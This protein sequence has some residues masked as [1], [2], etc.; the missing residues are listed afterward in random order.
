MAGFEDLNKDDFTAGSP[1]SDSILK[2]IDDFYS[3]KSPDPH[4]NFLDEVITVDKPLA[5]SSE[6]LVFPRK[7][8]KIKPIHP[9]VLAKLNENYS[10]LTE[11][12]LTT[13]LTKEI[14]NLVFSV[15]KKQLKDWVRN[16]KAPVEPKQQ[17]AEPIILKLKYTPPAKAPN[18][19]PQ[20]KPVVQKIAAHLKVQKPKPQAIPIIPKIAGHSKIQKPPQAKSIV[21]KNE[22]NFSPMHITILTAIFREIFNPSEEKLKNFIHT[23]L[24]QFSR[25][26]LLANVASKSAEVVSEKS[27]VKK[28]PQAIKTGRPSIYNNHQIELLTQ[29]YKASSSPSEKELQK[30]QQQMPQFSTKQLLAWRGHHKELWNEIEIPS[31]KS[32]T[33]KIGIK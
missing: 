29:F 12:T 14:K 10:H 7:A 28:T 27:S 21:Q 2:E 15:T 5:E 19:Q 17:S 31:G 25:T 13:Q 9:T 24:P 23:T 1:S 8:A 22:A 32:Q 16:K 18:P 30:L 26:A 3:E 4:R 6:P 11:E 20:R 33:K